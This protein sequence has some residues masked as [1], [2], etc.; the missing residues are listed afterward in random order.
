[1]FV[2]SPREWLLYEAP[3]PSEGAFHMD[4]KTPILAAASSTNPPRQLDQ[5]VLERRR[6]VM[7][8]LY[9]IRCL[10]E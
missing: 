9:N 6:S 4:R 2:L 3:R 5:K 1:M 10:E 7:V 8:I